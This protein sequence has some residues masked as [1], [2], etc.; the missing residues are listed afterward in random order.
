MGVGSGSGG[1]RAPCAALLV[2][3]AVLQLM[4]GAHGGVQCCNLAL[5][6]EELIF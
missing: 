2:F 5:L 1:V 3:N 6:K 4:A